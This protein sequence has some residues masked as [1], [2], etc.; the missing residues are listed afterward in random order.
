MADDQEPTGP[1][2]EPP[3]LFRRRG[4][5]PTAPPPGVTITP[6]A[7]DSPTTIMDDVPAAPTASN[8]PIGRAGASIERPDGSLDAPRPAPKPRKASKP[9]REGP[10]VP[11]RVAA[12]VVGLLVAGV[13]IGLTKASFTV[14]EKW[15]GTDSCGGEGIFLLIAI[16]VVA[17]VVG[18]L[19]LKLCQVPEPGSTSFMAVGL[20]SVIAL[21]FLVDSILDWWMLI[22]IPVVSVAMFLFAHWVTSTFVEPE[23][24]VG[25]ADDP[26][27]VDHD[28]R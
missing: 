17:V 18:A 6:P 10:L 23:R 16:L 5:K 22:A 11:G 13:I 21:L 9:P 1:S 8:D 12:G 27:V 24:P 19:I 20:T 25:L 15:Q 7:D 26:E 2:L 28:V 4:K 3:S 14:C